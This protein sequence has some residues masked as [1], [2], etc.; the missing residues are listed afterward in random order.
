MRLS[1]C[2]RG[3]VGEMGGWGTSERAMEGE[4]WEPEKGALRRETDARAEG[5]GDG[6]KVGWVERLR[7]LLNSARTRWF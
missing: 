1:A 7:D 2:R 5:G 4:E 3:C 6:G